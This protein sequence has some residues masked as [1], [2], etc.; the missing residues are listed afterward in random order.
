MS[1]YN[2]NNKSLEELKKIA[3]DFNLS[4]GQKTRKGL[5]NDIYTT[6]HKYEQ[7]RIQKNTKYTKIKQIGNKGKDGIAYLV[8][9]N[10]T[11]NNFIMKV[12]KKRK[13]SNKIKNEAELQNIA[14]N[15]GVAPKVYDIDLANKFIIMEQLDSHLIDRIIYHSGKLSESYQKKIIILFKKLDKA[16]VFHGDSNLLNYMIKNRKIYLIRRPSIFCILP[17]L[18]IAVPD[19]LSPFLFILRDTNI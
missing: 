15:F 9:Q 19:I 5:L 8:K 6:F 2:L 3:I 7:H 14:A 16:K 18:F 12:F 11:N 10:S 4:G 1:T 17:F 13:S